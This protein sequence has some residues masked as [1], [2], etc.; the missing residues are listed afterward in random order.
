MELSRRQDEFLIRAG[1]RD[2][3]SNED[4]GTARALSEI[5]CK[6]LNPEGPS[7]VLVGGLGMGFSL[8]AALDETNSES[9]VEVAE[10]VPAVAEWNRG[11]LGELAGRPLDDPRC[12][13]HVQ[14]VRL[15]IRAADAQYDAILLDVDNGPNALAHAAN[16][17][18]YGI[19]GLKAAWGALKKG[20]VL[21]VWS[22]SDD[23]RFTARLKK[24]GFTT[25]LHKVEG[26][27]KGRGRY[28]YVWIGVRR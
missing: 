28:H 20:G 9:V 15:L 3:M 17:G 8:R 19:K 27:R 16:N 24:Q 14:D 7:R 6:H 18:L 2:L 1:G 11:E 25:T 23:H 22:F 26:S 13:L 5:G 10:L 12:V 4:E 21:G